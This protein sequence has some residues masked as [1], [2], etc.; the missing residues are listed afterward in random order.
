MSEAL[1]PF[2]A[3]AAESIFRAGSLTLG[4]WDAFPVS[5][6]HALLIPKRHVVSWFDATSDEQAELLAGI[7]LAKQEIEKVRSTDGFNIGVNIGEAA[8]QTVE[9]LHLH[10]IPRFAGDIANPRGGVR[11]VLPDKADYLAAVPRPQGDAGD[12]DGFEEESALARHLPHRRALI[13]G[14]DDPLLPHV[15]A[16]LDV[17][18]AADFA[19]AFLLESGVQLLGAHLQDLIERGGHLRIVT[20]TYLGVTDPTALLQLLDL[21]ERWPDR[22]DLR[23]FEADEQSF[24]PKA[25]LF[26]DQPDREG[27]GVALVG[28]S[29]LTRPALTTGLE[30]NYRIIPSRDETGFAAVRVAFEDLLNHPKVRVIDAAWVDEYRATRVPRT[31]PVEVV[32]EPAPPPPEPHSIQRQ[33][34]AA[35]E[36]TREAGNS[37][38]LVVLATGLG[39]TWLSA[40]DSTRPEY[41]RVLFVAHRDEILRQAMATYRRIRPTAHLGLY[42]GQEKTPDAEVVFA[43]IQTIGREAHLGRFAREDF[44]YIV[45][46]EF[47]HA[48]ARTYRRLINYFEPKF[49]LGLTAT[50]ERTDGGDLLT[51]CQENMVFRCDLAEGIREELLSPFH[52]FGVPDEVDYANIPWRSSRFD[53]TALTEAVATRARAGNVL[54]QYRLRGGKQTLAFCCSTRHADFMRE[55]FVSAGVRAAAVHSDTTSDPRVGSLEQL[56]GGELDVVFAVDMFNEGVDLPNVDTV[57]M[58]RPTES[59]ILWLQQFGRGLR[60]AVGKQRLTVVDYIGNH[61]TFLLKPQTLFDLSGGDAEIARQLE[62]L[63]RGEADLPPGCEVTYD[64]KA[65]DILQSLLRLGSGD[66]AIR[67]F[68]ED[69]RERYGARPTASEMHHEGYRPRSVRQG[70]GSWLRFV[71]EMGD[72]NERSKRLVRDEPSAS[73]LKV[74]ETTPMTRSYKFLVL[75]AML[76]ANCFPGEIRIDILRDGIRRLARRSAILQRDFSIPLDDDQALERTLVTQ[77]IA[78]WIEGKGTGAAS[79]FEYEEGIFRTTLKVGEDD[80]G[81]LGDLVQEIAE[82]RLAEYIDRLQTGDGSSNDDTDSFV[83]RVSHAGGRPLLFLPPRE[84]RPSIPSDWT[85][86]VIADEEYEANFVKVAVNI[87]RRPGSSENVLPELLRSWFGEDAGLPGPGYQVRFARRDDIWALEPMQRT[88]VEEGLEVGRSYMRADIPPT[89]GLE[90]KSALWQQGYI[91]EGGHLF[92][93]VTLNKSGMPQEHRYGDRFLSRDLFEWKSQNRHTQASGAGQAI[94]QHAE[95]NIPVHLLIRKT[96]KLGGKASPFIFCGDVHFVGWE[97]EKPITVRWRLENPLSDQLA[98]L[99]EVPK[100]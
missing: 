41:R 78:A 77:P 82:W 70:Y 50:P 72:L 56:A 53:E 24:H 10:V 5:P 21:K 29:N 26:Y 13:T 11:S 3:P 2:C 32:P 37:A 63:Q 48:S 89:F 54:E 59:R 52:N 79:F 84:T 49:L 17:A 43:S 75:E 30:W 67:F 73:F 55:F 57:M 74:L 44:D 93:L 76:Q 85:P 39:K 8:G 68:Y 14:G 12:V 15:R 31:M 42:T 60:K 47:H 28:S 25:Y 16:Y 27:P 40:F 58:L 91:S 88:A 92:L 6:G 96:G 94:S 33:A 4:L 22:L 45:V 99:L 97:G 64:L 19:V 65:I 95:R 38:G 62:R 9:H 34:L 18:N 66:A 46:D 98:G 7:N 80:R 20:G 23:A 86:V 69:F 71:D 81:A 87:V 61:R 1:C 36:A 90:F 100:S 51:L 35:L 83:C